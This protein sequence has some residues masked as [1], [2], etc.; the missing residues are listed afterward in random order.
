MMLYIIQYCT[1]SQDIDSLYYIILLYL[2][3]VMIF[4]Y[5]NS[6]WKEV[7]QKLKD[8]IEASQISDHEAIRKAGLSRST[9]YQLFDPDRV[10]SPM[11]KSTVFAL[12]KA[13]NHHA[14]YVDGIPRFSPIL[15]LQPYAAA[16]YVQDA[17]NVGV[18]L[19]GSLWQLSQKS[20]I[21]ISHLRT[22]MD[23]PPG[24]QIDIAAL[25][26]LDNVINQI[27]L[28]KD[29]KARESSPVANPEMAKDRQT[30]HSVAASGG[31][32]QNSDKLNTISDT[33]L[34][35]LITEENLKKYNISDT[36]R[37][38]LSM[39]SHNR[40]SQTT[41]EHWVSVLF[42]LRALEKK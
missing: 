40:N 26:A 41:L 17:I 38:E 24:A 37:S 2:N 10:D 3:E 33:G 7:K 12:A 16:K 22:I 29:L 31:L 42:T 30:N 20:K 8:L 34:R 9:Y 5:M 14:K 13:L 1:I 6:S 4:L 21:D 32:V 15:A 11:H 18:A 27:D 36:E 23:A 35:Q 25:N 39:I 19:T 28:E